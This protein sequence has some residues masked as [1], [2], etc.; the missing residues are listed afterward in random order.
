MRFS[1]IM[2]TYG[3]KKDVDFF[4]QSI[5]EQKF[6]VSQIEIIIVDQNDKISL[7]DIINSYKKKLIIKYIKSEIKGLSFNRNIGLKQAIGDII[8]FPDD[9]CFYYHNTLTEVDRNLRLNRKIDTLLG[10][11]YDRK[12]KKNVIRNWKNYMYN[13]NKMNFFFSYT[14]IT[15]FTKRNSIFFD[16]NLGV[17]SFFGSYE[18]ADYVLQLL[19]NKMQI[20]FTPTIEVFHP[21]LSLDVMSKE[22][23]YSYGLGFGAFVK[24]HLSLITMTL[25]FISV[26]FHIFKLFK[27]LFLFKKNEV[28]KRYSSIISRLKG[29]YLY[30]VK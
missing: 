17:G 21:D 23:A 12:N 9:D 20:K 2:A 27:A 16:E 25:F 5:L 29:F 28:N 6:D 19:R 10:K 26:F 3:R 13:V 30:D 7:I 1:L 14:S 22:K 4:L 8:A 11:V 24:K 15:I 18:D